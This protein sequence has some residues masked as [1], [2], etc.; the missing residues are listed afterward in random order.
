[1]KFFLNLLQFY[2][3]WTNASTGDVH[4]KILFV[5]FMEIGAVKA[6]LYF[7]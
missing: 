5:G 3:I 7:T 6:I 4:K 1:M 2:Q